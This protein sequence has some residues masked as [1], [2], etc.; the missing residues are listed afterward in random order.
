MNQRFG[1]SVNGAL[2]VLG[3]KLGLT[4]RLRYWPANV[5]A[6][7]HKRRSHEQQASPNGVV[8]SCLCDSS[9]YAGSDAVLTPEQRRVFAD[10]PK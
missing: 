4:R 10:P 5:T 6:T 3:D 7:R 2:V 8:P 1:A 9:Y